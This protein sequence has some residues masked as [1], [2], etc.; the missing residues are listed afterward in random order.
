MST[1][2]SLPKKTPEQIRADL[3]GF[4]SG[5][6]DAALRYLENGGAEALIEM[7]PGMIAFYLPSGAPEPPAL[8][9]EELRLNEDLGLDS[10]ALTEMAFQLDDSFGLLIETREMVGIETVGDLKAFL[11]R[12]IARA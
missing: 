1:T 8:L 11:R 10:L 9:S 4:P 12:K 2:S 7:L 5:C 3:L 6:V